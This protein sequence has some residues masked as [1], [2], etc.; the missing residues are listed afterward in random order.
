MAWTIEITPPAS[1]DLRALFRYLHD[2]HRDFGD[3][4]RTAAEKARSRIRHIRRDI[5]AMV[6]APYQGMAQPH[7]GEGV[8]MVAKVRAVIYFEPVEAAQALRI[9]AV[10]YG[11]Q[12]HGRW[13]AARASS[14][15]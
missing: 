2:T 13:M 9:L 15:P 8:R 5:D 14:K 1:E 3:S 10:F 7:L 12:D 6:H 11:G 4:L